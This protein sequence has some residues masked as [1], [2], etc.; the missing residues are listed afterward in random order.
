V[1]TFGTDRSDRVRVTRSPAGVDVAG[2]AVRTTI[3]GS[4]PAN[5]R[6]Q[7]DT[8]GG[9]DDVTVAPDVAQLIMPV[10]D[11]GADD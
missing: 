8:L 5:D 3:T 7:V 10:V 4:E 1:S 2:L 11:L 9:D 6:L